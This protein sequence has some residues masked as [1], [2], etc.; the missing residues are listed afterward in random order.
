MANELGRG[1]KSDSKA[2]AGAGARRCPQE[3][4]GPRSPASVQLLASTPTAVAVDTSAS[5][6]L[7][8][9][10]LRAPHAPEQQRYL[11]RRAEE[12]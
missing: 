1:H 11:T 12:P 6:G 7:A 10:K 9:G 2:R 5:C 8:G 3:R 4:S